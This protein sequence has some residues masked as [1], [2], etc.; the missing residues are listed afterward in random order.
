MTQKAE[1]YL[2][3]ESHVDP[4]TALKHREILHENI[5][6]TPNGNKLMT[7]TF[8]QVLQDFGVRNW[9]GRIYDKDIVMKAITSNPLLQ[10][11]FEHHSL[12]GEAGHPLI[13]K[14]M[15]ELARQM[16]VDPKLSCWQIERPWTEG[17][18]LM[19]ECTTLA[20]GYGDMVMNRILTGYPA[21]ASSRAIGGVDKQGHVMVGYNIITCLN[22]L[23]RMISQR[24]I[25]LKISFCLKIL[26]KLKSICSVKRLILIL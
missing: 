19:S 25:A 23:S 18:L 16:T 20:G 3:N 9:N 17:N 11:D 21:Q 24:M 12:C 7:V 4:D 13:E 14:G 26:L 5:V 8:K 6:T 2:I 15:N 1:Y 22:L 10:W